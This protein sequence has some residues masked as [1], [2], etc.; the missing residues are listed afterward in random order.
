MTAPRFPLQ[1]EE[2]GSYLT[3]L[4]KKGVPQAPSGGS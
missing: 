4:L 3:A 2:L 1:D